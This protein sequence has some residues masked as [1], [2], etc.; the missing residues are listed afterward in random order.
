[1]AQTVLF[2]G[3]A[4]NKLIESLADLILKNHKQLTQV[5]LV[6]ILS[7]GYPVA[8]R[9]SRVLEKKTGFLPPVGKLDVA[10]YRDDLQARG[11]FVTLRE[12]DIPVDLSKKT[13]ILV[14]DVFF[15]GRTIRAAFNALLDF[16]RAESIELA[17]LVDRGHRQI[18][19]VATYV[20]HS[21]VTQKSD[22]VQCHLIEINGEDKLILETSEA[23]K[24]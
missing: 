12:S 21:L 1:M 16:G 20:A 7:A 18:P 5:V 2:E 4:I 13:L 9:L 10:L 22:H 24:A 11:H 14:D 8:Q 6:G 19:I 3:E 15:T 23:P 17:V